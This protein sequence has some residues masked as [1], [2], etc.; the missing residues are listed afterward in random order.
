MELS[1]LIMKQLL[2]MFSLSGIGFL[3]A[4]LKLISNEGCKE[5]VNLSGR[6]DTGKNTASFIFT[7]AESCSFRCFYAVILHYIWEKKKS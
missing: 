4:K 5:L 2:V 6:K 3:L 7:V 1:I